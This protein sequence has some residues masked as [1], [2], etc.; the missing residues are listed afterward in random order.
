MNSVSKLY[1]I[2]AFLL[3]LLIFCPV[4]KY[5]F[6]IYIFY[7]ILDLFIRFAIKRSRKR[8]FKAGIKY[9]NIL[10]YLF[11]FVFK[12]FDYFVSYKKFIFV[13][14]GF[15]LFNIILGLLKYKRLIIVDS[16]LFKFILILFYF[17]PI[18]YNFYYIVIFMILLFMALIEENV[19]IFKND[20][21]N[22]DF[23]GLL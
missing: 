3:I 2:Q 5:F 16:K 10:L 1:I 14:L 8:R 21:C 4:N 11:M 17:L 19:V 7:G 15:K 12:F 9:I 23:K 6:F 22:L 18:C 20:K 13:V